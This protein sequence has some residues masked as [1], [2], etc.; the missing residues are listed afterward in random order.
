LSWYDFSDINTINDVGGGDG[1]WLDC[2]L[3]KYKALSGIVFDTEKTIENC[4]Q[5]GLP[6][7]KKY[8]NRIQF[9]PGDFF[10]SVPSGGDLY[11]LSHI[12]HDWNDEKAGIIL[13]N[14]RRSIRSEGKLLLVERILL[15]ENQ[16]DYGKWMD[17]NMLVMM[18]GQERTKE[19]YEALLLRSG[20]KLTRTISTSVG[21][22]LI[23]AE[24]V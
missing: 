24:P 3:D 11:F 17:L 7:Q 20:F 6:L 9:V 12:L 5:H 1:C 21:L 15:P 22:D 14:C 2:L 13:S 10:E 16:F 8:N 19:Q 4:N 23:E 18:H